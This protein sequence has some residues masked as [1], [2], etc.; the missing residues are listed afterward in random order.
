LSLPPKNQ[1]AS[2]EKCRDLQIAYQISWVEVEDAHLE[3]EASRGMLL[4]RHIKLNK[5]YVNKNLSLAV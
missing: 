5:K 4:R 2:T 3:G 1:E